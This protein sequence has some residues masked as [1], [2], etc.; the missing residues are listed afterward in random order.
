MCPVVELG[1]NSGNMHGI[2][3]YASLD[4]LEALS[5]IYARILQLYFAASG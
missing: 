3:E 1:L 2:D 5:R 4:D